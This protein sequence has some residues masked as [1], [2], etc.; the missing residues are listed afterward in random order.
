M[1]VRSLKEVFLK[2][3]PAR[4]ILEAD[5]M[6]ATLVQ[7]FTPTEQ[8]EMLRHMVDRV[9]AHQRKL[10]AETEKELQ[11]LRETLGELN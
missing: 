3:L 10:I 11:H 1:T 2:A 5:H 6:A 8:N 9:R 4:H 7:D